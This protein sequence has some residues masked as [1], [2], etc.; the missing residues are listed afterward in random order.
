MKKPTGYQP[1]ASRLRPK[2]LAEFKG[3]DHLVGEH[4]PLWSMVARGALNSCLFWGPPG[5]GKTTLAQILAQHCNAQ[6]IHLSAVLTQVKGIRDALTQAEHNKAHG[7]ETILFMDELHRLNKSQQDA[8]L[9]ALEDGLVW[10]IGATTENPGFHV[11]N[12]LLSRVQVYELKPLTPCDLEQ[13]LDQS[14]HRLRTEFTELSAAKV[15]PLEF[16]QDGK[17]ALI[18]SS[19]GDGRQLLNHL[20]LVQNYWNHTNNH[21]INKEQIKSLIGEYAQFDNKGDFFYDAISA[22]HKSVRGSDA[23]AALYWFA[24]MVQGGC[25]LAYLCRRVIRMASE[26]IGNA[27]PRALQIALDS[28]AA[29]E[30]LG[31]PEGEL[32]IAQAIAYL[33]V[34]P[35]SNAVYLAFKKSMQCAKQT[36]EARVPLHL[37]NAPTQF[38]KQQGHGLDYQYPHDTPNGFAPDVNYWPE[39]LPP[40][41]FYQPVNR[42]LEIKIQEKL[43]TLKKLKHPE[44]D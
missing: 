18:S 25:D 36:P 41:T 44:P 6:L 43:H 42:G 5:V 28:A 10:F 32:M 2:S 12:A 23:D 8:F 15:R 38:Q 13:L 17:D 3:Q 26:D 27:D 20:E 11:N 1:L 22:L 40:Q 33:S 35:K 24:K 30:R 19:H 7:R 37:R 29:Y 39:S 4:K 34:A 16:T 9:P 14:L 31:S 21:N